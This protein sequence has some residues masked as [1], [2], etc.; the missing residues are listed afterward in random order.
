MGFRDR[1]DRGDRGGGFRTSYG[2]G[3]YGGGRG[4]GGGD[5]GGGGGGSFRQPPVKAGDEYDVEIS[6]VAAKG[7][8][9]ARIEGFIIFV[10][11]TSKGDKCRIKIREVRHRFA[12]GDKV[13]EASGS[14][15]ATAGDSQE[16]TETEMPEDE[17]AA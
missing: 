9:I 13:G 4:G 11:G 12:I 2:G 5:R 1:G 14:S 8:G 3:G 17:T 6:D 15:E 10:A 16:S 7:D